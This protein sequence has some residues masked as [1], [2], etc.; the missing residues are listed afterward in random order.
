MEVRIRINNIDAQILDFV[1]ERTKCR[2]L[3]FWMPKITALGNG[4]IIWIITALMLI[5][6]SRYKEYGYLILSAM[7]VGVLVGNVILKHLF[8]RPRPCWINKA[9]PLLI[10]MP[11]DYSFPSG[12]TLSSVIAAVILIHT[13]TALGLFAMTASALIIFSRLYL[14]V[15]YPSDV[16][17]GIALGTA[18]SGIMLEIAQVL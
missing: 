4:G 1:H 2:F 18:I 12:H 17:G 11:R 9:V 6:Y 5:K 8:A 15:H 10:P 3:D 14:Y 7:T 16:L 13:N